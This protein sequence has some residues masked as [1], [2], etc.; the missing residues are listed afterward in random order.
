MIISFFGHAD[1]LDY[2]VKKII[3]N[4]LNS[5]SKDIKIDFYLGG[6][7]N[8]DNFA[9]SVCLE[10]KHTRNNVKLFYVT[11]YITP[12]FLNNR[13]PFLSDYDQIIS[14]ECANINNR[15]SIIKRNENIVK[16]S[17][18]IFFYVKNS[19]G[20]AYSAL[21]YATRL[22]KDVLNLAE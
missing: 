15:L 19:F 3:L 13:K 21:K 6:Y 14:F 11:P 17:D 12:S 9:K 18:F 2:K 7:G 1:F 20:G 8:F 22:K 10:F 4:K 16:K 5:I